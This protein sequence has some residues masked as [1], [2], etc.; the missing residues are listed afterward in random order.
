[1]IIYKSYQEIPNQLS[2]FYESLFQLLLQRH[3]GTKPG[4]KRRRRCGI[5]DN[6]YRSVFEGLCFYSKSLKPGVMRSQHVYEAA[7]HGAADARLKID[8]EG[9]VKDIVDTTCLLLQEAGEYRFIHKS[10]QEFYAA[11]L[12]R[13]KPDVIVKEIYPKLVGGLHSQWQNEVRFLSELDA[14]RLQKF[15]LLPYTLDLLGMSEAELNDGIPNVAVT[16]ARKLLQDLSFV[17]DERGRMTSISGAPV[18]GPYFDLVFQSIAIRVP[19]PKIPRDALEQFHVRRGH[20]TQAGH[21]EVFYILTWHEAAEKGIFEEELRESAKAL[22]IK[23]VERARAMRENVRQQEQ[24]DSLA[25][26]LPATP[27]SAGKAQVNT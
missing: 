15:A 16:R 13:R 21:N 12:L 26:V 18:A 5:N 3:D 2:E 27:P 8:P 22:T 24:R 1:V 25:L 11:C 20:E 6:Q 19:W 7:E 10:V 14:Y 9:F 23:L 17:V 4:Y